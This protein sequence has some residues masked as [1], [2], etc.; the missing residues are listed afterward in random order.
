MNRITIWLSCFCVSA[1]S[2]VFWPT[3]PSQS[4]LAVLTAIVINLCVLMAIQSR[5][6]RQSSQSS[7]ARLTAAACGVVTGV[8][9]QASVGHFYYAWQ[10]PDDKIQQDVTITGTVLRG[11]CTASVAGESLLENES[12]HFR[13]YVIDVHT[14][15]RK[16][17]DSI[18]VAPPGITPLTTLG[19]FNVYLTH[20]LSAYSHRPNNT[21]REPI[22]LLSQSREDTES[23]DSFAVRPSEMGAYSPHVLAPCLHD[24]DYFEAV[25]KLKPA[26]GVANP[27]GFNRQQYLV[28]QNIHATGYIKQL[29]HKGLRHQHSLRET[30]ASSLNVL[31]LEQGPWWFALL[32]GIRHQ[33]STEDWTLLKN[34][35]TGHLFSISGMHLGI[36]ALS[37]LLISNLV[38]FAVAMLKSV[39]FAT[40]LKQQFGRLSPISIFTYPAPIRGFTLL[41]V[42]W[43]CYVYMGISG[44]ALPVVRAYVLLTLTCLLALT[45]VA[46]RP[47]HVLLLM[48]SASIVLFPLGILSASFYLSIGAVAAILFFI[49]RFRLH[50]KP[51]IVASFQLQCLLSITLLP[52]T[53]LWFGQGSII[54]LV[55]NLIAVPVIMLL[56]PVGFALLLLTT[57]LPDDSWLYGQCKTIF[58]QLDSV[59]GG[60]LSSLRFLA[61]LPY[62]SLIQQWN[63]ATVLCI[64]MLVFVLFLP[65]WRFKKVTLILLALGALTVFLPYNK[66]RW[67][68]HVLDAGQA[69]AIVITQGRRAITVDS[70]A[71]YE[72]VA[73]TAQEFLI[74]LV[75]K[76][77]IKTIDH[78]IHTH[79]DNDHAG[80]YH[81][82]AQAYEAQNARF[83]SPTNGCVRG[84]RI[85]WQGLNIDFLWPKEGNQ[86]DSNATSCVVKVSDGHNAVLLPGDIEK[87]SEYALLIA[88]QRDKVEEVQANVLIAPHHGSKTSSTDVFIQSVFFQSVMPKA[89]IYT[90]GF[91]NR[92][93]FPALEVVNRYQHRGVR[94]LLTSYHGY[95]AINFEAG[96]RC[97]VN[98][99]SRNSKVDGSCTQTIEI[100]TQRAHLTR[101]W[102]L[103]PYLPSHLKEQGLNWKIPE[104]ER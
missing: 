30:L 78:V 40:H 68:V 54:A 71:Q 52:L 77:Q 24:G 65:S 89:V 74:P 57:Y 86:I 79:S 98:K 3:L 27:V 29:G 85:Q 90:Q 9:W 91:E 104:S 87:E 96:K 23:E 47:I 12:D 92:W 93:S 101:R 2:A 22:A 82:L 26:Y 38:I 60:L 53:V 63:F 32:L 97:E 41:M 100:Q 56:L 4:T 15:D 37:V 94:Q 64:T 8:I 81:V 59:F 58:A 80:G 48:L 36:I 20:R 95:M 42:L 61:E 33:L 34:T 5:L 45:P 102:Y 51:W 44:N 35:G 13:R 69:T 55:T 76:W 49:A 11:G 31:Q 14:L 103:P 43:C 83:Y 84:K 7:F 39:S 99:T 1:I 18:L 70:G 46:M 50:L 17:I 10:L 28:S 88:Q 73:T 6:G 25:V 21:A 72:G 16:P 66:A 19:Q 62:S 67:T 75:R